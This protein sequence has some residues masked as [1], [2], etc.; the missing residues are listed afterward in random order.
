VS[1]PRE[2]RDEYDPDQH[3]WLYPTPQEIRETEL[4]PEE[5]GRERKRP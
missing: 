3:A 2:F 1:T 5:R 4:T